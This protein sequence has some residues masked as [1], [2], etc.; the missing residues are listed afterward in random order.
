MKD[1]EAQFLKIQSDIIDKFSSLEDSLNV[2]ITT[3]EWKRP[4]GGGGR[5]HVIAEGNFFDNCAINFSSIYGKNIPDSA[6]QNLNI[7]KINYGYRAMGISIIAHPKNPFVPTSHMNVR[8]MGLL[9]KNNE[10]S[11]WWIGGGYDLTP[12]FPNKRDIKIWHSSAKELLDQFN[13]SYYPSFSKNCNEYFYL[14]HRK[15]RRGIGG[16]FFDNLRDFNIDESII[17]L[18]KIANNFKDSY[19]EIAKKRNKEDYSQEQ[20][21]FQLIRRGRYVEFNL[22]YDRGTAF[23]LQSNGR[24]ESIL[25]SLPLNVKW[26]YNKSET[27]KK[28]E[29]S[30]LKIIN[31]DWNV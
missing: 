10:F 2:N 5:T 21:D 14:P 1:Y 25:S 12:Y 16:I 26:T 22:V 19:F 9:N 15:E 6:L 18:T 13:K 8:L 23:G 30:L 28:L 20:K 27:Y 7:K 24:I 3:D 29:S 11:D 31:K 17:F 4:E